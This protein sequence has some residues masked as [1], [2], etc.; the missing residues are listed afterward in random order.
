M[1]MLKLSLT[2]LQSGLALLAGFTAVV[3]VNMAAARMLDAVLPGSLNAEG[4]PLTPL[5]QGL[6]LPVLFLAGMAGAF[7]VVFVAPRAP[8]AHGLIFGGLALLGDVIVVRDHA[9][10]WAVWFSVLVV[11]TVPLQV[12][13]GV[14]FGLKARRRWAPWESAASSGVSGNAPPPVEQEQTLLVRRQEP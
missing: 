3:L 11:A 6:Y 4:L 13:L 1:K 5:A 12:W 10:T 8:V 14:V 7:L 2:A 9:A